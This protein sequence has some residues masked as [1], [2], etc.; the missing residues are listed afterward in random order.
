MSDN[1]RPQGDS[2]PEEPTQQMPVGDQGR[3]RYQDPQNTT[4]REPTLAEQ[5][6]RQMAEQRRAEAERAEQAAAAA[7]TAKRRKVLIGGGATVGVV[8]L[9]AAM[10]SASEVS[11]QA[12]AATEYCA[13]D[14]SGQPGNRDLD[15]YCDENYVNS[16]GGHVSGGMFFM[17]IFLPGGGIGGYHSYRYAYTPAGVSAPPVGAPA[18]GSTFNK[19]SGSTVKNTKGSTVQRGGFGI[20]SKTGG[21]GS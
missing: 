21:S 1:E 5:K 3:I 17:P 16:H 11:A 2:T 4:P 9:V 10:Y 18:A 12:N 19:P 14:Q 8:A 7:K 6:A 20:S 15:E 13:T